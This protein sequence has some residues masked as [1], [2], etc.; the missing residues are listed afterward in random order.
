MAILTTLTRTHTCIHTLTTHTHTCRY[1][2][3]YACMHAHIYVC[4]YMNAYSVCVSHSKPCFPAPF[5]Q[6][7][8]ELVMPLKGH[9]IIPPIC[10]PVLSI[11]ALWNILVLIRHGVE[12]HHSGQRFDRG[13]VITGLN[14]V[15][16]HIYSWTFEYI[17]IYRSRALTHACHFYGVLKFLCVHIAL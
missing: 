14:L 9:I 1:A 5:L 6:T 12:T 16:E 4:V 3:T 8:P 11:S 13:A 10:P 17:Y 15:T 2:H 7:L